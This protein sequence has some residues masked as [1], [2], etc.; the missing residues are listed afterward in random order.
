MKNKLIIIILLISTNCIFS[1]KN[2]NIKTTSN[3]NTKILIDI[4]ENGK[5]E[6]GK[7]KCNL[8]KWEIE[9]PSDFTITTQERMK[10]LE[11]KAYAAIQENTTVGKIVS[12]EPNHLIGFE[13]DKYTIFVAT[14]QSLEGTKKLS[15]EEHKNFSAKVVEET[16]SGKGI[17]FDLVKNDLK[18]G[19]HNFYKI[20]VHLYHPK[21]DQLLLTQEIYTAH[22]NDHLFTAAIYYQDEKLGTILSHN[23]V[24]SFQ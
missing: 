19:V 21:T 17:K 12:R 5:I 6:N 9:I 2:D 1:Q 3:S 4:P 15:L 24:K 14:Y 16:Y 18:L 8:F 23:F 22:I 20:I 11:K 7:Y 13:K 10:Q